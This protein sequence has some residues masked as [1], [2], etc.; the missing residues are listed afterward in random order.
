MLI[1]SKKHCQIFTKL[2]KK[3]YIKSDNIYFFNQR[4]YG[5]EKDSMEDIKS[6]FYKSSRFYFNQE[7]YENVGKNMM[8]SIL[9]I[10]EKNPYSR[11]PNTHYKTLDNIRKVVANET[12]KVERFR[13]G[14]NLY[15]KLKNIS[16][17]AQGVAHR[18]FMQV[19]LF[20][21]HIKF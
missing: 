13:K 5:F 6:D 10:F 7:A 20:L 15:K 2:T 1:S 16:N 9:D 4:K 11:L 17:L 19:K 14:G 3:K 12:T 18:K 21:K 8:I